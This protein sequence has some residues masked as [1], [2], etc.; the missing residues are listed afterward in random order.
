VCLCNLSSL[1]KIF[2]ACIFFLLTKKALFLV[3]KFNQ[4]VWFA[5]VL[6]HGRADDDPHFKACLRQQA[7]VHEKKG[8]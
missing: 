2:R 5:K 7:V 8:T 6:D 4:T 3:F 1:F